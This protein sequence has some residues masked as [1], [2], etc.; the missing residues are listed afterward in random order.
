MHSFH[1]NIHGMIDPS[2]INNIFPLFLFCC[3]QKFLCGGRLV[4]GHD[5]ASL[6]LT[7]FLIGCPALTFC[8]RMVVTIKG[9]QPHYDY[10]VLVAGLVLTVLVGKLNYILLSLFTHK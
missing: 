9:D 1:Y 10:P 7:T 6:Y 8:I 4:F 3:G 5:A 2:T